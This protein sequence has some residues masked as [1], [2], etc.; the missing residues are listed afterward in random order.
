MLLGQIVRPRCG[1]RKGDDVA[2]QY[3]AGIHK[4]SQLLRHD[5]QVGHFL[6]G[7]ASPAVVRRH[8]HRS[9]AQLGALRPDASV[10]ADRVV[11]QLP[12]RRHGPIGSEELARRLEKEL[13]IVCEVKVHV[14]FLPVADATSLGNRQLRRAEQACHDDA[15][16]RLRLS[17]S[18]TAMTASCEL[19]LLVDGEDVLYRVDAIGLEPDLI[20]PVLAPV[21]P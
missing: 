7:D 13:L 10:E 18:I 12:I 5:R 9:P 4:A 17:G 1:Q 21:N 3:R 8:Q 16:N 14:P 19:V 15:M 2:R 11:D 6:T 20:L